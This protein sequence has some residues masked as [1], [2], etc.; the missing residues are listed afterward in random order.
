MLLHKY[1]SYKYISYNI[2]RV[3]LKFTKHNCWIFKHNTAGCFNILTRYY[4]NPNVV[5]SISLRLLSFYAARLIE[6]ANQTLSVMRNYM[7]TTC[8]KIWFVDGTRYP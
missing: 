3:D 1:I 4:R 2:R 7:R 8:Q 5:I 6:T